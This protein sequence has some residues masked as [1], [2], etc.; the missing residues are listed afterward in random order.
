LTQVVVTGIGALTPVGNDVGSTWEALRAGRSGV[1][2]AEVD[3]MCAHGT[4]TRAN[5]RT[6][7]TA[8]KTAFGAAADHQPGA[9]RPGVRPG[10]RTAHRTPHTAHRTPHTAR[11]MPVEVAIANA[12]GF[13]GQNC[14]LV[15][16]RV[17]R[18]GP[19]S[20]RWRSGPSGSG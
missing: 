13:G 8:I 2:P 17:S 20:R 9:S 5:D 7:T 11:P 16:C 18:G 1:G 3:Y 6:E 12:F 14:V 4:S 15:L 19:G 10:F